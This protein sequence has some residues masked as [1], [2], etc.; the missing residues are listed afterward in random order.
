MA[1]DVYYSQVNSSLRKE[2]LARSQTGKLNRSPKS[3]DFMLSKLTNVQIQAFEGDTAT[4]PVIGTLG[5]GLVTQNSEDGNS[6]FKNINTNLKQYEKPKTIPSVRIKFIDEEVES[7]A[8]KSELFFIPWLLH[9][10]DSNNDQ[11]ISFDEFLKILE[12]EN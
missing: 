10:L 9:L 7:I 12:G 3:I 4:T 8:K 11:M 6:Y 1:G 2:L 5:G